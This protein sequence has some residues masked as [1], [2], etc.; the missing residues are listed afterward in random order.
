M[1]VY[2]QYRGLEILP[3][4]LVWATLLGAII[5]SFVAPYAAIFFILL[6]DTYWLFRVLYFVVHLLV[7]WRLF[8]RLYNQPWFE[9]LKTLPAWKDV[10]HLVFLPTY[11]EDVSIVRATLKALAD[12]EYPKDRLIVIVAGEEREAER[13]QTLTRTLEKEFAGVFGRL[14]FTT[15]PKNTPGDIPGKGSNLHYAGG[16]AKQKIAEAFPEVPAE[17]FLATAFDVDTI[18]PKEYFAYLTYLY[19]TVPDPTHT[20]F[21][22]LTFFSNNIWYA[23]APVRIGAFGTTFWLLFQLARPDRLWT[24]SSHSMPWTM[25]LDVGFWQ[26]D[27]VSEDSRIFLQA[28]LHYHGKYRVTPM[29]M[30]VHMDAV[31]G[32]T[33]AES[34][35]ALYKQQRRWAWGVEHLMEMVEGFRRDAAIPFRVKARLLFQHLEGMYTWATAPILIFV[36]GYVPI[37]L[38][39]G[40]SSALVQTAPEMLQVIMNL[41][42]I[43][44]FTSAILFMFFLPRRPKTVPSHQW[45]VMVLQWVLLPVT[46]ILFSAFPAIDAQTRLMFGRYLGFHVTKKE[47]R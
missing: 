1:A 47:R 39:R 41:A 45:I 38:V 3:G 11:K 13:F 27:I 14:W 20:S 2:G 7:A 16:V 25:L 28:F 22:P 15:H 31:S 33:Y 30:G 44:V 26:R 9:K 35:A 17:H 10:Y 18:A 36:L 40:S 21:Q 23:K 24:F 8:R 6:F 43:G 32:A 4:A 5:A 42:M 37:L 12:A 29:Y 34:L 46:S 19:L